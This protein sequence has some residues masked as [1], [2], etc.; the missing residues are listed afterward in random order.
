MEAGAHETLV[1]GAIAAAF[2]GVFKHVPVVGGYISVKDPLDIR[3][4]TLES[5]VES[6]PVD[7]WISPLSPFTPSRLLFVGATEPRLGPDVHPLAAVEGLEEFSV[8]FLFAHWT[9]GHDRGVVLWDLV[10]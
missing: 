1:Q 6:R 4:I 7:V 10:G 9:S 3:T 2:D 5:V 8:N